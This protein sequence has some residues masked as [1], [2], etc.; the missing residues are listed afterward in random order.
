MQTSPPSLLLVSFSLHFTFFLNIQQSDEP[1]IFTYKKRPLPFPV[2]PSPLL[3]EIVSPLSFLRKDEKSET[4]RANCSNQ[5]K[6]DPHSEPIRSPLHHLGSFGSLVYVEECA[7]F[8]LS[9]RPSQQ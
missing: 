2:S 4:R 3:T 5:E 6:I 8:S 1:I 7:V 9:R